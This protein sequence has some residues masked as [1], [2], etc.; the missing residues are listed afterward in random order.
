MKRNA[1]KTC[2]KRGFTLI[3]LLVVVLMIGILAA[4]ALPQYNKAVLKS[5]VVQIEEDLVSL[6]RAQQRY[7]W[8][9]DEY[10]TELSQ[11]DIEIPACKPIPGLMES[12]SYKVTS[13]GV[14]ANS[15][16][17][18]LFEYWIKGSNRCGAAIPAGTF[19]CSLG[20]KCVDLGFSSLIPNSCGDY[21]RP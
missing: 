15:G 16:M 19:F 8:E 18:G 6:A 7:Y 5:R 20:T 11:L 14:A 13:Q 4:V 17:V 3:E 21:I 12:C 2:C 9:H 10:A 1:V